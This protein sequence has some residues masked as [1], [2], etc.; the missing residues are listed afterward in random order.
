MHDRLPYE[1]FKID[2]FLKLFNSGN[3]V[4]AAYWFP[5]S[6]S[7]IAINESDVGFYTREFL[8]ECSFYLLVFYKKCLEEEDEITLLKQKNKENVD[9]MF[10]DECLLVEFTNTLYCHIHFMNIEENYN[11]SSNSIT[12]L[13]HKFGFA[14]AKPRDI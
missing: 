13:E 1:L 6:L 12:P 10:Y 7:N 4:A 9:V 14:R 2:N 3:F 8:L 5:I 11:F